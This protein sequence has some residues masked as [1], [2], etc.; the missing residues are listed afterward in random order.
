MK[1]WLIKEIPLIA[2]KNIDIWR[3]SIACV[4]TV[5]SVANIYANIICANSKLA[6]DKSAFFIL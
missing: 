2:T 4:V 6:T 3:N 5:V 1:V